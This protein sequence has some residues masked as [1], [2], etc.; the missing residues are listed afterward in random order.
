MPTIS[1]IGCGWL[2][3][4]CANQLLR[5]GYTVKGS[6]TTLDKQR[7]LVADGIEAHLLD[8]DQED[9]PDALM[10]CDILFI[11]FPPGR[12]AP[13]LI[14]RYAQRISKV[15]QAARTSKLQKII[16]ASTTGVYAGDPTQAEIDETVR[17]NPQRDSAKAMLAAEQSLAT[18]TDQLTILRF[19]GLVGPGR[20]SAAFMAGKKD[21]PNPD[22]A[23]NLVHL[24]DCVQV[25]QQI[26]SQ[27]IFGYTFNVVADMHPTRQTYYTQQAQRSNLPPPTFKAVATT[28]NKIVLNTKLK[29]TL[30]YEFIYPDPSLFP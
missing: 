15:I 8:L 5:L 29:Q 6:T 7:D 2:G 18:Y 24:D 9:I 1:I 17:P 16:F 19:A 22:H 28:P 14:A 20:K 3:W 13:N 25:V 26:I 21:L 12:G 10:D 23:V 4:P 11:T 27:D 30:S